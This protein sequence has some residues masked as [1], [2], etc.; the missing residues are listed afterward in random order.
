MDIRIEPDKATMGQAAAATGAEHIRRAIAGRG[1][2]TIVVATGASQFEMLE[3]LTR[4][5][6]V[7]WEKVTV[8][9][10]DEYVGL[11]IRHPASFRA[12]L[13]QRFH[14]RLPVPLRAFHYVDAERDPADE[15]ARLSGLIGERTVDV[16]F[17]GIGENGHLAFNDPPADFETA[18][19]YIIVE[20]DD[21]CCRQQVGEGWFASLDEVPRR[22]ISMSIR[23]IMRAACIVCTVPDERKAEAVRAAVH[24]PVR[25]TLPASILQ[26]HANATLFLDP[27]AAS[28]LK[29][30]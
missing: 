2:A 4:A 20:L 22:A 24:G 11:S 5:D 25:N 19:P 17:I 9:H 18:D 30:A 16:A 3:A 8:F 29:E 23:E 1:E 28:L 12:Y 26:Q 15:C 7:A 13:W 10:L 14:S 27:P 21:A 6:G